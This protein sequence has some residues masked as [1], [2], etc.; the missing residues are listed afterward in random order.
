MVCQT[1]TRGDS[2]QR[3]ARAG[4]FSDRVTHARQRCPPAQTRAG[5]KDLPPMDT[6]E[7]TVARQIAGDGLTVFLA[8]QR[9][10]HGAMNEIPFFF[11]DDDV[12][13]QARASP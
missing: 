11:G 7:T 4:E 8:P 2:P 12:D 13:Y 9:L 1:R 5:T 6:L 3:Q 10:W